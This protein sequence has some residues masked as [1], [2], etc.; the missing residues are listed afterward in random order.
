VKTQYVPET[1]KTLVWNGRSWQIQQVNADWNSTSGDSLILNKPIVLNGVKGDTGATGLTGATG[2]QGVKGDTGSQGIQGIQG[3]K[4]DTGATGANG[5]NGTNGA[6]GI[7]T[8]SSVGTLINSLT[9][10]TTPV[11][12]D[13]VGL[14]DSAASNIWKKL[15]WANIKVALKSYFDTL[16]SAI[17]Q[18]S[19]TAPALQG[20]WVYYGTYTTPGYYKDTIGEVHLKGMVKSGV[21]GAIFILP[22]G[23]RPLESHSFA[24]ISYDGTNQVVAFIEVR[25]SNGYVMQQ[26]GG[27]NYLSLDGITFKAEQ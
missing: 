23:C 15:S 4:G 10:K 22:V 16:Y 17:T 24:T 12:A 19:W 3:A 8:A 11:D 27:T 5:T 6:D 21:T 1:R 9:A 7:G 2:P 18:P 20:T 13:M 26:G 14:M 25:A